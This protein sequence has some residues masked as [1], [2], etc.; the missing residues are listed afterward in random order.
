F[1]YGSKISTKADVFS[2]GIMV[3]EFLTRR[4]PTGCIED[5]GFPITLCQFV[6]AA[7]ANGFQ[8]LHQV[9]DP[10][11]ASSLSTQND[12]KKMVDLLELALSCTQAA[13]E[14]R[15][16][17]DEVL[18]LL[19][20]IS[21]SKLFPKRQKAAEAHWKPDGSLFPHVLRSKLTERGT[22]RLTI[23]STLAL[24]AVQ[25][26]TAASRSTRPLMRVQQARVIRRST[27][28]NTNQTTK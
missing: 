1:A 26:H 3:M 14:N 15:P 7:L 4:R 12:E 13:P 19:L 25:R 9:M 16:D 11:L 22:L 27:N 20:T 2:F 17:M 10:D 18:S 23:L 8:R 28:L 24:M 21:E 6:E 5:N